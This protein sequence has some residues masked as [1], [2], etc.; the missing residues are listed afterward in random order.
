[1]KKTLL[2]AAIG[3]SMGMAT[4][5]QADSVLFP[6][7]KS[8][9]ASGVISFVTLA[10]VQGAGSPI[11][12]TWNF[13]RLSEA[14]VQCEH[15]DAPGALTAWDVV[16]HTVADPGLSGLDLPNHPAFADGSIPAY[17]LAAGGTQGFMIVE[18]VGG[19]STLAGQMI[20]VDAATG[21]VTA[22]R[23]MN[24]PGSISGGT[25][26]SI[27]T[28]H[29]SY[30]LTWYPDA[31]VSTQWF[32]LVTGVG[33]NAIAGWT[34]AG[35]LSNGFGLVYD[36]NENPRSGNVDVAIRCQAILGRADIMTPEQFTHSAAGGYMWATFAPNPAT[37]GTGILMTKIET[38]PQLGGVATTSLDNP[39]P[40]LPF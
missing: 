15:E 19:E 13:D 28:S 17:S 27:F 26:N 11:A 40:N 29:P 31:V 32:T 21:L 5:V 25:W 24:N 7:Y 6:Y 35:T 37:P 33:M 3:A 10:N 14:G 36:Q 22:Y 1:M 34:G 12:Y 23:G 30:D 38:T 9:A 2:A 16:H 20:V 8:D 39:W 18:N 4:V